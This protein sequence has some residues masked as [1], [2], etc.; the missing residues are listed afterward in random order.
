MTAVV[1]SGLHPAGGGPVA[2]EESLADQDSEVDGVHHGFGVSTLI[3]RSGHRG[4]GEGRVVSQVPRAVNGVGRRNVV[5]MAVG[6]NSKHDLVR[7][8]ASSH[9]SLD[10]RGRRTSLNCRT[11]VIQR[12]VGADAGGSGPLALRNKLSD[13]DLCET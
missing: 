6:G 2:V 3:E 1:E 11:R 13:V 7:G 5:G 4:L 8:D 10:G 12:R 9:P